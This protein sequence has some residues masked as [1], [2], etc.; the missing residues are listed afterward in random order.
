[1]VDQVVDGAVD[2][3]LPGQAPARR[4][5]HAVAGVVVRKQLGFVLYEERGRLLHQASASTVESLH[6]TVTVATAPVGE[7]DGGPALGHAGGEE[8]HEGKVVEGE[9]LLELDERV[10]A[11]EHGA[12]VP[13]AGDGGAAHL[14]HAPLAH[15]AAGE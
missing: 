6:I 8:L 13:G 4:L 12:L 15:T 7:H 5:V 10:V 2:V 9:G 1:M 11:G 3:L 14:G